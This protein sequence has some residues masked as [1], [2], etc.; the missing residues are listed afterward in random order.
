M[1]AVLPHKPP[2]RLVMDRTNCKFGMSNI[3]GLVL[4][5]VY[6]G[7][8]FPVLFKMMPKF[9]NSSVGLQNNPD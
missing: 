9:G 8:A 7:I 2:Y 6:Q 3:N 1:F 4:A 5:I